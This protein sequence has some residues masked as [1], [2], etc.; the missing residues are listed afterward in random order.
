M[1][2]NL[3]AIGLIQGRRRNPS[4][5]YRIAKAT[6]YPLKYRRAAGKFEQAE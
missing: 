3:Q 1:Q 6:N 5:D 2:D 4:S